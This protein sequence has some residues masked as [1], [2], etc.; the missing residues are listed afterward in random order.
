M[1]KGYR[2][3]SSMTARKKSKARPKSS[4]IELGDGLELRFVSSWSD[5]QIVELYRSAGWWKEEYD[6]SHLARMIQGSFAFV[7]VVLDGR[8]IAMGRVISDGASDAYIQDLVTLPEHRGKGIGKAMLVALRDRCRDAGI[9]WIG[10]VAEPGTQAFYH[11]EGF[12]ALEGYTPMKY[13]GS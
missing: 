13:E 11:S 7:V 8:A 3:A 9:L 10:L 12:G 6:R 2:L 5:D 1:K 4:N